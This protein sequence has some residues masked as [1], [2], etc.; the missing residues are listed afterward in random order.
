LANRSGQLEDWPRLGI[1]PNRRGGFV[2]LGVDPPN[3]GVAEAEF[4][5]G[6]EQEVPL[7]PIE[8]FFEI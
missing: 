4:G 3:L 5:Q 8:S 6:S 7:N 1:D 2:V